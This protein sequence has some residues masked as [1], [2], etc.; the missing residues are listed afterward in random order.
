MIF[1]VVYVAAD[2]DRLVEKIKGLPREQKLQLV[3]RLEQ[4]GFF[5]DED[6]SWYWTSEWQAAEKE[7]D[8]DIAA[9]RAHHYE[10]VDDLL[11]ALRERRAQVRA[12][13]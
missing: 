7:A 6:Q 1:G 11:K 12:E 9:G 5:D 8:E 13:P 4:G 3:K 2:L 10:N